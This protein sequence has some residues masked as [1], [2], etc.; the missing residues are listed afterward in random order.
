MFR[1]KHKWLSLTSLLWKYLV[2]LQESNHQSRKFSNLKNRKSVYTINNIL[3]VSLPVLQLKL[4]PHMLHL[5]PNLLIIPNN[6]T[7]KATIDL[8]PSYPYSN[9]DPN[10]TAIDQ[11][12]HPHLFNNHIQI[13]IKMYLRDKV[14]VSWCIRQSVVDPASWWIRTWLSITV[15]TA[16][17]AQV[18]LTRPK[19][20]KTLKLTRYLISSLVKRCFTTLHLERLRMEEIHRKIILLK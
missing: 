5:P 11:T 13:M 12:N 2:N 4:S 14:A 16:N 20:R 3:I 9:I 10:S 17:I 15:T 1:L 6:M 7:I 18:G 19:A 8:N